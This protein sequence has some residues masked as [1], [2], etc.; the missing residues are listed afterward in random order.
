MSLLCLLK[1]ISA[2]MAITDSTEEIL[3]RCNKDT[4]EK[5]EQW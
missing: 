3:L 1:F 4:C 5:L 2:L